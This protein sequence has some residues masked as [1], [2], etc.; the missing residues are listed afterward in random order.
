MQNINWN[1]NSLRGYRL[2]AESQKFDLN[3]KSF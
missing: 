2:E 1:I 3:I